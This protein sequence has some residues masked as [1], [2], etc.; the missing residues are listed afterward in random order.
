[1]TAPTIARL[2]CPLDCPDACS[3]LVT[4]TDGRL[5]KVVGDPAHPV[6]RGF[7]CVKTYR[8]PERN[9]H[10]DRPKYPQKRVGAKGAGRWQRLS[11]DDALD[12]IA[13]K[14]QAIIATHGPEAILPYHYAGTM[15]LNQGT[16]AHTLWRALGATE[17]DETIC[18]S[19][20]T[21]AW[22]LGYG[23]PRYGTDPEDVPAAKL[24]LLWGINSLAT[25]SHL[26]PFLTQA[27]QNGAKIIH[28]DPYQSRTSRFADEH[29]RIRP[30]T[31]AAL[32][33]ALANQIIA[34]GQ[35]DRAYIERAVRGFDQFAEAARLWPLERA[36]AVTGIEAATIARLASEYASTTPS[37]IRL[38]YG[39]TRTESGGNGL[40]AVTCLPAITGQWQYQGGGALLSTSGVFRLN[41]AQL[42][43]ADLMRAGVRHVN[44][45]ELGRELAPAA[46]I[47]ALMVYNC[48]PAVVAPDSNAVMAGLARDDLLTVVLEQA[49]TETAEWADYLLPAST[50]VEHDDLYT[51]YGHHYLSWNRAACAPYYEARPNT[52]VFSQ[53]GRRLGLTEAE[54]PALYWDA[55]RLARELLNTDHP[56]LAD[57]DFGRLEREGFVRLNVPRPF[58]PYQDGSPSTSDG[59][60]HLDPAPVQQAFSDDLSKQY[61]LRLLTPPAHHF[62]NSTYGMIDPLLAA[63]GGEPQVMIHPNDAAAFA[64][65]DGQP[66]RISSRQGSV[67]RRARITEAASQGV[68][69][70]EGTWWGTRSPDRRGINT[71]TSQRLT[72]IAGGSSF[73]NTPVN[74]AP[75]VAGQE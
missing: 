31:D 3:L 54:A 47:K 51:A 34:A 53:L 5:A 16:H 46:G 1:V 26:T 72:D 68:V 6:S 75:V 30:G 66:C 58:L 74:L 20:G 49:H 45:N 43:G 56:F 28:I 52:W 12:E 63:E 13:A 27:R 36:S 55:E 14:L 23:E 2:T 4:V 57:I 69:V 10:P 25:N 8:Y 41:R 24:I 35:H 73:H 37:F 39:M 70:V 17:L 29:I 64:I 38:G 11:W 22:S 48:N 62:L 65:T 50:F 21:A 33:L 61:P 9:N 44:M 71:L 18:A 15:G 67:V 60:I 32:A 59:R 40:R 42:G 7:A 19:T